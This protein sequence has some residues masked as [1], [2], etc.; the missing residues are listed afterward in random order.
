MNTLNA[1]DFIVIDELDLLVI[2]SYTCVE[3]RQHFNFIVHQLQP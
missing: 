1:I 3:Y 2:S